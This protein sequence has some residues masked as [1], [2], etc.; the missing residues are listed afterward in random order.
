MSPQAEIHYCERL[1]NDLTSP[2]ESF[3][4]R[5]LDNYCS[6]MRIAPPLASTSY[7]VQANVDSVQCQQELRH[8]D[9]A[10]MVG[11]ARYCCRSAVVV[12]QQ[13]GVLLQLE[14]VVVMD[15]ARQQVLQPAQ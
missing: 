4:K 12:L 1:C 3:A 14:E 15:P 8:K 7:L 5:Q 9:Q 2:C 13:Q 10:Q 11:L 6:T